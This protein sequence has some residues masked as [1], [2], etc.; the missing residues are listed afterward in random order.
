GVLAAHSGY[1][2]AE[3]DDEVVL[4]M[5]GSDTP[6]VRDN[7]PFDRLATQAVRW[8]GRL[9][10][11][12]GA[13]DDLAPESTRLHQLLQHEGVAHHYAVVLGDH[14]WETWRQ[15][16]P[17]SLRFIQHAFRRLS[18]SPAMTGRRPT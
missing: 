17:T 3:E 4:P 5:L 13:D 14:S 10:F 16:L 2:L 15:R 9:Y 7:S 18:A 6:R 8:A 11:D 12:C 1:F